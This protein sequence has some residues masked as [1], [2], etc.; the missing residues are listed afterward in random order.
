MLTKNLC[1]LKVE[2]NMKKV[3]YSVLCF[4]LSIT[5]FAQQSGRQ[6]LWLNTYGTFGGS[7]LTPATMTIRID[8]LESKPAAFHNFGIEAGYMFSNHLGVFAGGGIGTYN[9]TM[10]GDFAGPGSIKGRNQYWE[11]SLAVHYVSSQGDKPG[12]FVQAGTKLN[13]LKSSRTHYDFEV[14]GFRRFEETVSNNKHW[15]YHEES[16]LP[17]LYLGLRLPLSNKG[18]INIGPEISYQ[19]TNLF[20]RPNLPNEIEYFVFSYLSTN[21]RA[22]WEGHHLNVGLKASV[23]WRFGR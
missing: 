19:V 23:G 11:T 21:F 8:F 7:I 14:T 10:K 3:F 5:G 1:Y 17:Y 20:F 9:Y 22:N 4:S 6:G 15:L 2:I 12:I 13:F 16:V 18:M